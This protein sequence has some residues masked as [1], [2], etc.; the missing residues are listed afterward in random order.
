M[1]A[2][3]GAGS[4][5]CGLLFGVGGADTVDVRVIFLGGTTVD[6]TG[7]STRQ[8]ITINESDGS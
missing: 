8:T 3:L 4:G 5:L 2:R 6:L 7:V 1:P